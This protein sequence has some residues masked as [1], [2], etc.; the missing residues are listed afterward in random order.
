MREEQ[1]ADAGSADNS[2]LGIKLK[3]RMTCWNLF[4]IFFTQFV[5]VAFGGYMNV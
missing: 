1:S 3:K 2:V 5:M 4:S